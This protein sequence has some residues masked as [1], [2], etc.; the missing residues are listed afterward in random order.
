MKTTITTR[1]HGNIT[2]FRP[3]SGGYIW[4][5]LNGKPGTLGEQICQGGSTRGDCL[6]SHGGEA[7]FRA[8][9]RKWWAARLK[10]IRAAE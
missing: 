1:N 8:L 5:D 7:Q 4:A 6:S 3:N 2:F 9:C 10:S